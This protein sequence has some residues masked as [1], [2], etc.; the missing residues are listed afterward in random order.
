MQHGEQVQKGTNRD[1]KKKK[2]ESPKRHS[3]V[4]KFGPLEQIHNAVCVADIYFFCIFFT[5]LYVPRSTL[6]KWFVDFD[7][8][9]YNQQSSG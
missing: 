2:K 3:R 9:Y 8:I 7:I 6:L 4:V 5:F 1:L